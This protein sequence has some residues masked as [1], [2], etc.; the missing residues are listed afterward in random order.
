[1]KALIL[2]L[3][4]LSFFSIDAAKAEGLMQN[5]ELVGEVENVYFGPEHNKLNDQY[6]MLILR[7][8]SGKKIAVVEDL[9]DCYWSRLAD[10]R[11][12]ALV[13]IPESYVFEAEADMV[14]DLKEWVQVDEFVFAGEY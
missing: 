13:H 3:V 6:C 11:P 9:Y 12:D 4:A 1:M 10:A 14:H 2:L 7:H 5:G 8:E